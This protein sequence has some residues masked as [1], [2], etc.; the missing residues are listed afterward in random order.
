MRPS[1]PPR[2][3]RQPISRPFVI[4]MYLSQ[5]G[6]LSPTLRNPQ[7]GQIISEDTLTK[8]IQEFQA[9]AGLN[10][11]GLLLMYWSINA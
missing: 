3:A 11:T 2:F 7:S 4:L 5:F 9:F 10:I 6:Y 1:A 8:A